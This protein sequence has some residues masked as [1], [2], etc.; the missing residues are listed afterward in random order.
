MATLK[1]D[2]KFWQEKASQKA[3]KIL[4]NDTEK[5]LGFYS[6]YIAPI[7]RIMLKLEKAF[8]T[9]CDYKH[10]ERTA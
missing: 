7:N 6:D 4:G 3:R 8:E 1:S 5:T 10:W 9:D 2:K